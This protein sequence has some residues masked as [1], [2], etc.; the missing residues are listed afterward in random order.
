MLDRSADT[1]FRIAGDG[2]NPAQLAAWC[3]VDRY[4]VTRWERGISRAPVSAVRL[5]SILARGELEP[6]G[7]PSWAGWRF[8]RDGLL[9][10]PGYAQG[11]T[12]GQV[13]AVRWMEQ[14]AS[15]RT[16]NLDLLAP[17]TPA[18]RAVLATGRQTA[19]LPRAAHDA[20]P[21]SD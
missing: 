9:Y 21:V 6:L 12:A 15:W 3:G 2:I 17:L 10:G 4:T 5:V 13:A 20:A 1:P 16:A 19:D 14:A 7:G 11:L 8:G 18:E